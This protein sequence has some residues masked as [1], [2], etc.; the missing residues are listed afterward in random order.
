MTVVVLA[1]IAV[2]IA[3]IAGPVRCASLIDCV[4]TDWPGFRQ[5]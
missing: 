3:G 5:V 2:V 1:L 4:P